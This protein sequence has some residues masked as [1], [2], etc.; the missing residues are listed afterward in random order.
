MDKGGL[1]ASL[2]LGSPTS[3]LAR[4]SS[5]TDWA[6]TV[7]ADTAERLGSSSRV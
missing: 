5:R 7:P 4:F 1:P 2:L 3:R 6:G